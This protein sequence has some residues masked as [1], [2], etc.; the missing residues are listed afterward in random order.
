[1]QLQLDSLEGLKFYLE[2]GQVS[3]FLV[4]HSVQNQ[5]IIPSDQSV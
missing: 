3:L 5:N 4:K 2:K 1:M